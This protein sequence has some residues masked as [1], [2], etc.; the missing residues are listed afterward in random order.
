MIKDKNNIA[1]GKY[2]F[3]IEVEVINDWELGRE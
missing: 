2:L 1:L 3:H